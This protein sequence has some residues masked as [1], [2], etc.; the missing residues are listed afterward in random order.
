M[1]CSNIQLFAIKSVT[2]CLCLSLCYFF[3]HPGGVSGILFVKLLPA[4]LI[5]HSPPSISLSPPSVSCGSCGT[6]LL[7]VCLMLYG[8]VIFNNETQGEAERD[9]QRPTDL[10]S[11]SVAPAIL[12]EAKKTTTSSLNTSPRWEPDQTT[13]WVSGW[14]SEA[15]VFGHV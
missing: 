15:F 10:Q 12:G 13:R 4:G 3:S 9:L 11:S 6:E 1:L 5:C 2:P 8:G 7:Y 14:A